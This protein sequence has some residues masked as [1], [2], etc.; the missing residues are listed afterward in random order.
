MLIAKDYQQ[1]PVST[2][3]Q[4]ISGQAG[5][6][7]AGDILEGILITPS[8]TTTGGVS[9]RDGTTG[10]I[11][12]V[13]AAGI[14]SDLKPFYAKIGARSIVGAWHVTTGAGVLVTA[15]GRFQ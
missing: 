4:K 6:G 3:S 7:L 11:I 15:F 12:E 9:L 1:V 13:L 10:A 14:L 2:A 5:Q 8:A